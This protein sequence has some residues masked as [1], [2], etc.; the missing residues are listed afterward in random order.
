MKAGWGDHLC[1]WGI[2][3]DNTCGPRGTIYVDTACLGGQS[4]ATQVVQ[5]DSLWGGGGG[6][7]NYLHDRPTNSGTK[8]T[9]Q[10]WN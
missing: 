7:V 9:K 4:I 6:T 2:T 3:Y 8:M 5:E 1:L 10:V